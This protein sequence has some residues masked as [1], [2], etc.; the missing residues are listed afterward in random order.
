MHTMTKGK[1]Q[2]A[3]MKD[4]DGEFEGRIFVIFCFPVGKE[5]KNQQKFF[6]FLFRMRHTCSCM[7]LVDFIS[8]FGVHQQAHTVTAAGVHDA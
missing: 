3:Q 6:L 1:Q 2:I 7:M 4:D 5:R 8:V